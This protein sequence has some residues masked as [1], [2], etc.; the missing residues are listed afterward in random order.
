MAYYFYEN[1]PDE[2]R[3]HSRW[4]LWSVQRWPRSERAAGH[5]KRQVAWSLLDK[6]CRRGSREADWATVGR[7]PL[8]P[9]TAHYVN[10]PPP[11]RKRS[12]RVR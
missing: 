7:P 10:F 1:Y 11:L 3:D 2:P 9:I 6:P 5:E 8:R 4:E 12:S